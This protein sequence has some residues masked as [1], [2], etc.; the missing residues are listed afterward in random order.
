[1]LHLTGTKKN[2][3]ITK[4]IYSNAIF[5]NERELFYINYSIFQQKIFK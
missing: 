2:Q 4:N 5:I 1:M 3:L